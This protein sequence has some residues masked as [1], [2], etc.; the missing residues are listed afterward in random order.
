VKRQVF[1]LL[2]EFPERKISGWELYNIMYN[3]TNRK[4][5]PSTL[6]GFLREYCDISG[7]SVE[8]VDRRRSVYHFIP[9]FKIGNAILGGKE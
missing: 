7:A 1:S 9:G 3:R 2:D 5:Y 8:C 6:L 4:T